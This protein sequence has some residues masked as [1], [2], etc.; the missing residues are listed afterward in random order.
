[1]EEKNF[2]EIGNYEAVELLSEVPEGVLYRAVEKTTRRPVLIKHYYPSLTW[3][4]ETLNELFNL[5]SY[6][7]FI[8]HE[9]LLPILD[10]G[11]HGGAPY[12][13]YPGETTTCLRDQ[14]APPAS[15][16]QLLGFY[17]KTA[18]ALDFLHRQEI[19]HGNLN[20]QNILLNP[21]GSPKI[22]DYGLSGVFKKL[23][24]E[25]LEEGFENLSLSDLHTTAP[26]QIAGRSPTRASDIYAYGMVL[27]YY[28]FGKFPLDGNSAAQTAL[29][30]LDWKNPPAITVPRHIP[31]GGLKLIQKCIQ[32][33]PENRFASFAQILNT[34]ERLQAGKPVWLRYKKLIRTSR[35][36]PRQYLGYALGIVTLAAL[37]AAY[38]LYPRSTATTPPTPPTPAPTTQTVPSPT[39]LPDTP[40]PLPPPNASPPQTTSTVHPAP[41]AESS[42]TTLKPAME[43]DTP[44]LPA[45]IISPE[46]IGQL[47]ELSRLG[48]GK[49][50]DADASAD[51]QYMAVATSAGV[52]LFSEST[53]LKWINPD[54][55]ATSVQFGNN[56][57]ILA[58]GLDSGEIQLWD[59][60][61]ET[62]KATLSGHA[63][64]V[65]KI[66]FSSNDRLLYTA[67]YDRQIIVWDLNQD[68][69]IRKIP[70]HAV[71]LNDI[72]VSSDGKTLVSCA[73]DQYIRIWDVQS[74]I[75]IHEFIFKGK[76]QAVAISSDNAYFAAAGDSGYIY[77]WKLINSR[78]PITT[79]PQLRTDP[80]PVGKRI[81]SLAYIN[82]DKGLLAGIDDGKYTIYNPAQ[83]SYIGAQRDA[84]IQPPPKNL[85]DIFGA[86]FKFAGRSFQYGGN[87]LSLNWD[88][89]VTLTQQQVLAPVYD[90]LDRLDFSP[91]G[92]VLASGG[93][94]GT[95][96]V[97]NVN[98]NQVLY[99]DNYP[100]PFGDPISP[101][102]ASIV[103]LNT[104]TT[105][106]TLS[107][108]HIIEES[109]R[110]VSLTG[111]PVVGSLS[112]ATKNGW[113]SY[114]REGTVLVSANLSQSKTWDYTNGFETFSTWKKTSNCLITA[115]QND[116]EILQIL[117]SAGLLAEWNDLAQRICTK[118]SS[119]RLPTASPD[120]TFMAYLNSNGFIE[121]FNVQTG[122]SLWRYKPESVITALAISPNGTMVAAGNEKGEIIFLDAQNGVVLKTIIGNFKAVR[123]IEF[124][125]DG[126]KMA[127]AGDDGVTRLFG[128]PP[129][130]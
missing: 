72:A 107:G 110:P 50:E 53:Y 26:E 76:P 59:W 35:L 33:Q 88:G 1:M 43:R 30:L 121:G 71:P 128:I 11:K 31:G 115:S 77:Q 98:T 57:D 60:K 32:P 117:S 29:S 64:K 95:V 104:K 125:E 73:D 9:N 42:S 40:R 91:D 65:I 62:R 46:N 55:W 39:T 51:N 112:E 101:D 123:A 118:S 74:G 22:L 94:R 58:I 85:L 41:A 81:W 116:N 127:T 3:S 109:Y 100:I 21:D 36:T 70:A 25:N 38:F 122:Q 80:I 10:V 47:T 48:Y 83:L 45:Q 20:T 103:I 4:E 79:T 111:A 124:S 86:K 8:E 23:L 24:L 97:W 129:S 56:S 75:K 84:E 34:V 12:I 6:L 27:Y 13:V 67:G 63:A 108:E 2:S 18:S 16:A 102:G 113:V 90:I 99:R 130:R 89:K 106:I 61:T 68:R 5:L 92:S 120:L 17:Q 87:I 119:V 105:R 44:L 69:I 52:F 96:N 126:I 19:L 49:P 15:R 66:L 82:N 114:A 93:K 78:S 14:P 7:R 28:T 37:L 54:G